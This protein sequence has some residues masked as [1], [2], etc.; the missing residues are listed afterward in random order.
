VQLT[1]VPKIDEK[2]DQHLV[3]IL[4]DFLVEDIVFPRSHA[5]KFYTKVRECM[6]K[7]VEFED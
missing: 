4:E 7:R 1:Y 3:D 6:M 2:N 5:L